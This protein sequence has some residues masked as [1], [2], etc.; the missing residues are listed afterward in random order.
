MYL[1]C[2]LEVIDS[3]RFVRVRAL[4]KKNFDFGSVSLSKDILTLVGYSMQ[5]QYY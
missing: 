5:N 2:L 1:S 4:P 3:Y